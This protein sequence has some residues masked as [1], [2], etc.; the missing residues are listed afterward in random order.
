MQKLLCTILACLFAGFVGQK[1]Y[2]Q[3]CSTAD[4]M[5]IESLLEEL[6]QLKE[7]N[8]KGALE[9]SKQIGQKA[10]KMNY[11]EGVWQARV[12]Q[13]IV[14]NGLGMADSSVLIIGRVVKETQQQGCRLMEIK[15]HLGLAY[16]YQQNFKFQPGVDQLIQ[17]EKLLKEGDSFDLRF[18]ILNKQGI[19]HRLM[20]DY[21]SALKYFKI[22]EDSYFEQLTQRQKFSLYMNEGNVF[23]E[24]KQ[25]D[26][27]EALFKKAYKEVQTMNSPANQAIITYNL[28]ALFLKQKRYAEAREYTAKALEANTKI[29]D[30]AKIER[31][32]RMLGSI[33]FEQKDYAKAKKYYNMALE[34]ALSI[35][36]QNSILGDYNNLY[37]TYWNLG[38]YNKNIEDLDKALSYYKKYTLMKDSL[39]EI[40]TTAKVLELEKKYETEKKN[41]QIALLEKENQHQQ[42]EIRMQDT[43]RNYLIVFILLVSGALGIVV[44]FVYYYKR[45][46]RLLQAQSKS[47]LE[48]KNQIAEQNIQLQKFLNTQNR[49]FSIIA[50]DLRSPL[51]SIFNISS[52]VAYY[53]EDKEYEALGKTAEKMNVKITKILGLTDNLL[54]WVQSQRESSEPLWM[55]INIHEILDEC[56]EI[57]RPIA[58]DKNIIVE[59]FEQKERMIWADRNM[60]KTVCRNLINNAIKFTPDNGRIQVWHE[61]G[62]TFAR[63]IIKDSGTGI[64][65]EKLEILF[66][67]DHKKISHDTS[68]DKS[69]GLG[70]TICKEFVDAMK[71]NIR[72]ESEIGAGSQFTIELLQYD[73]QNHHSKLKG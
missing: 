16:V 42:D 49:L 36:N 19:I 56:L 53:I 58:M 69:S 30:R 48:Q 50:H 18:D 40:E 24:Q 12:E 17:A 20:K 38:Y 55:P 9:L 13:G 5:A 15:A 60:V 23:A 43:Q 22:I 45:V 6:R 10:G 8:L 32:Y 68:G 29:G 46:N 73:P 14:Y 71:G 63:I 67:I 27:T 11:P 44:Y 41:S 7:S 31:C 39:Y 70:L 3:S 26:Q 57:Y 52:L 47:I 62:D 54:C 66:E 4:S 21:T 51:V 28:G 35:K 64:V 34:I 65:K 2:S 72:V 25:Y 1:G 59:Y 61:P 37:Q 33:N